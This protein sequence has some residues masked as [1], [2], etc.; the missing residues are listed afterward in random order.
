MVATD[1]ICFDVPHSGLPI[2]K[3]LGEW[4]QTE[5]TDLTLFK[6]GVYW[7]KEGREAVLKAKT[8]GVPKGRKADPEKGIE[9][10]GLIGSIDKADAVF[11]LWQKQA[12]Y[13]P[14][15]VQIEISKAGFPVLQIPIA[16]RMTSCK[17]AIQFGRWKDAG[18]IDTEITS[19]QDSDPHQKR[20]GYEWNSVK[21]RLDT[22]VIPMTASVQTV[23]YGEHEWP[24]EPDMGYDFDGDISNGVIDVMNQLKEPDVTE[25][26]VVYGA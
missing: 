14:A 21:S 24:E 19:K 9:A 15:L 6:P 17:Q 1:G 22:F 3:K 5:Y 8:R 18:T 25:W 23:P 10:T 11:A 16:F 2:S 7:H 26:E 4:E 12:V 13:S 20:Y